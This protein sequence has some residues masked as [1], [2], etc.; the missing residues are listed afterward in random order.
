[1]EQSDAGKIALRSSINSQIASF[2]R[3]WQT[4]DTAKEI[5]RINAQLKT[6]RDC[7]RAAE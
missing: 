5:H 1:M 2:S 7:V 6:K 3:N 4:T